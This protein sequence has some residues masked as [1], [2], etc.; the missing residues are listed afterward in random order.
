LLKRPRGF[1]GLV[2][3]EAK[4]SEFDAAAVVRPARDLRLAS[5]TTTSS[6]SATTADFTSCLTMCAWAVSSP[7]ENS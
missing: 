6:W 2:Q 7:K 4:L 3:S 5:P 1:G